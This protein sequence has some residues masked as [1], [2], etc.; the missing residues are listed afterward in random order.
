MMIE[1]RRVESYRVIFDGLVFE[2][3]LLSD[4]FFGIHLEIS[5]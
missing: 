3:T 5:V 1:D 4:P 2:E